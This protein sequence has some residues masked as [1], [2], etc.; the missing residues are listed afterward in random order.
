M[1]DVATYSFGCTACGK[2]CTSSPLL[3]VPELFRHQ[4]RFIGCLGIR[5]LGQAVDGAF[6]G[7][8]F[9]FTTAL[10]HDGSGRCPQLDP[11]GLCRL[12]DAGKPLAC[13]VVPF[14]AL[15][16]DAAQARVLDERIRDTERWAVGCLVRGHPAAPESPTPVFTHLRVVDPGARDAL[17]EHRRALSDERRFW[18]DALAGSLETEVR[19]HSDAAQALASGGVVTLSL[20]PVLLT[21]ASASA[22]ARRRCLDYVDAQLALSARVLAGGTVA[23][24][25]DAE[26]AALV[27]THGALRRAL[28][29][30]SARLDRRL[31]HDAAAL[32][33]WLGVAPV[34]LTP[35]ATARGR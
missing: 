35:A 16:P 33:A 2:C 25:V 4:D 29:D 10:D 17:A 24:D 19:R 13:R 9:P 3:T 6:A 27:R 23:P 26:L 31:R 5:W 28:R 7:G 1:T 12:H 21:V 32:E 22:A 15:L 11:T 30:P 8:L 18:G 14:D 20:A 34:T